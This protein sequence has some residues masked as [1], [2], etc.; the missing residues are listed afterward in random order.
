MLSKNVE[1]YKDIGCNA[2]WCI[3]AYQMDSDH[4]IF[5]NE[6]DTFSLC[7]IVPDA[8]TSEEE[9]SCLCSG[10]FAEC[11]LFFAREP[12]IELIENDIRRT[13]EHVKQTAEMYWNDT[14]ERHYGT[15]VIYQRILDKLEIKLEELRNV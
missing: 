4:I 15:L 7:Q 9:I 10:T 12:Q 5:D 3:S 8:P 1:D 11:V 14:S 2:D 13:K 6:D